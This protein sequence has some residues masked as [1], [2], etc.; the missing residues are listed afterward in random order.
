M[1]FSATRPGLVCYHQDCDFYCQKPIKN[2]V[3]VVANTGYE[4]YVVVNVLSDSE[5]ASALAGAYAWAEYEEFTSDPSSSLRE[6]YDDLSEDVTFEEYLSRIHDR[7]I[8]EVQ[9]LNAI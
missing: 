8:V 4:H 2:P 6:I 1:N 9:D 3:Y 7:W 5:T